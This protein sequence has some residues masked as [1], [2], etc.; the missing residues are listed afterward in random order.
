MTGFLILKPHYFEEEHYIF[1]K[2]F[3]VISVEIGNHKR[4]LFEREK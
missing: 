2:S 3:N 4:R 1:K